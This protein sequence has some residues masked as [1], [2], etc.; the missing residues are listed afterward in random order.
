MTDDTGIFQH[1]VFAVPN[2][3]EGYTTDDNAR[4]LIVSI[5]VEQLGAE[6]EVSAK[7]LASRYLAFL[8]LA[9]NSANG[10]FRNFLSYER[11]WQESQGSEDSHGRALWALGSAVNQTVDEELRGLAG[12]LF[13]LAVPAVLA[14]TSPRAWAFSLVWNP[15]NILIDFPA[16]GRRKGREMH[17]RTSC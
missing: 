13:E 11:Q 10:R 1:A 15:G 17:S 6:G 7:K 14:F 2:Q 9:F 5:L 16:T 3:H 12:R 4:A 8:W